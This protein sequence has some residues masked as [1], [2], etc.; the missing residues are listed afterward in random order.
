MRRA[1]CLSLG[2]LVLSSSARAQDLVA[3]RV[4]SLPGIELPKDV[5]VPDGGIVRVQVRIGVATG[6]VVVGLKFRFRP[7]GLTPIFRTS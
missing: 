1:L 7:G 4:K 2:L 3:P 6:L 5:D